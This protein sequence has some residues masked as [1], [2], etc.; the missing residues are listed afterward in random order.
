MKIAKDRLKQIIKEELEMGEVGHDE[1]GGG[2][3]PKDPDGYEG[4]MVK[5]NLWKIAEYAQKMHGLIHDDENLEPWVEEKIAVAAYMMDSVG[6]YLQYEK[7]VAHEEGEGEEGHV[8]FPD[9]MSDEEGEEGEEMELDADELGDEEYDDEEEEDEEMV[10]E[11]HVAKGDP[12]KYITD[13]GKSTKRGLW[14]NVH[15]KK[16]RQE[17]SKGK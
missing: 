3:Y 17:R 13:D 14:A 5:Q 11:G 6:H 1:M 4:R 9:E 12:S 16:Q 15:L 2:A 7:H 8:D 10:Y